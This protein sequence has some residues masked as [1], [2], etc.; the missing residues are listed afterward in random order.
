[1]QLFLSLHIG[2]AT[3]FKTCFLVCLG[4]SQLVFLQREYAFVGLLTVFSTAI[5]LAEVIK[6]TCAVKVTVSHMLHHLQRQL[7]PQKRYLK[8]Y[9][10]LR[11][12]TLNFRACLDTTRNQAVTVLSV[13][14]SICS[15]SKCLM[16][17]H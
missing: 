9:K 11:S 16:L 17:V 3:E 14:I 2:Y 15:F 7:I 4:Q 6:T 13:L 5:F 12:C 8:I 1:M 10:Q